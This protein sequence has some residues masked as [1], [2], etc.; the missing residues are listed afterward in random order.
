VEKAKR[1]LG[2]APQR[3]FAQDAAEL[4]EAYK[5]GG[6]ADKQPDFSL[7]EKIAAA[8]GAKVPVMA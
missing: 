6:G 4:V 3:T 5:A 1:V 7:D 2:W 8:T